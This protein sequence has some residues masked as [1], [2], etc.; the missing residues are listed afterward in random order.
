MQG[1]INSWNDIEQ[2]GDYNEACVLVTNERSWNMVTVTWQPMRDRE[3]VLGWCMGDEVK[4]LAKTSWKL[5]VVSMV[6]FCIG[7][8]VELFWIKEATGWIRVLCV[9]ENV[10]S[11]V[12]W[13][14]V[15]FCS[16]K[17]KTEW[18]VGKVSHVSYYSS[19][20]ILSWD[21]MCKM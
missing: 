17:E 16:Y 15:F 6:L 9:M 7:W 3:N 10:L 14:F 2:L 21:D 19:W 8:N 18:R 12:F 11:I 1:Y 13:L 20:C 4:I 5:K